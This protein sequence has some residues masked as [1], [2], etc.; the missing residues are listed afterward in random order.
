MNDLRRRYSTL[1]QRV[2]GLYAFFIC[3]SAGA[4]NA[5]HNKLF[6]NRG[7]QTFRGVAELMLG[8]INDTHT[9]LKPSHF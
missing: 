5:D 1:L 7:L 8:S 3:G 6:K 4:V 9:G 2:S